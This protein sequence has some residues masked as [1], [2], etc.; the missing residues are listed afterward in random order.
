MQRSENSPLTIMN[1]Q[2]LCDY[3]ISN[4]ILNIY[5]QNLSQ[6]STNMT[7]LIQNET[8]F[9]SGDFQSYFYTLKINGY[10]ILHT[11]R[12]K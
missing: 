10:N 7:E 1:R 6:E 4:F 5:F 2:L 8:G 11:V 12:I 3:L 9:D